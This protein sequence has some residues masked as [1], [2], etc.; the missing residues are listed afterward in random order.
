MAEWLPGA[1]DFLPAI[2]V[3]Q[4]CGGRCCADV[5]TGPLRS[6]ANANRSVSHN[7]F[8]LYC[9]AKFNQCQRQQRNARARCEARLKRA[10]NFD[11]RCRKFDAAVCCS[12]LVRASLSVSSSSF[13]LKECAT[14]CASV[15]AFANTHPQTSAAHT[16]GAMCLRKLLA[17]AAMS[18]GRVARC[19]S[20]RRRLR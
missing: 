6:G 2:I 1:F 8:P 13:A 16:A 12:S 4:S 19:G 10:R 17:G 9:G 7:L 14:V 20:T 18:V 11:G 15:F 5:R 3:S